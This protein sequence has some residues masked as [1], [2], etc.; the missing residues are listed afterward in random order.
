MAF[1]CYPRQQEIRR[2]NA[3]G[4]QRGGGEDG[5]AIIELREVAGDRR[6]DQEPHAERD[7]DHAEGLRAILRL[8]HI[9]NV[10]LR[11]REVPRRRAVD[12]ARQKHD[13]QIRREGE[14]QESDQRPCLAQQQQW[15]AACKIGRAAE[16]RAGDELARSVDPDQQADRGRA[17]AHFFGVERQ[18][19]DHDREAE[20]VD[21]DD[22]EDGQ[23]RRR[24]QDS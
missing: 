5:I 17:R 8:R 23:Q 3:G 20:H 15:F 24:A 10:G 14:D 12:H 7:A 1:L 4:R 21:G 9:G 16:Q 11:Q 19:R 13:P 22:Q 6:A 18:Q 2:E